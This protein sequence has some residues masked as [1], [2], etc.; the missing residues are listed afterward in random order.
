MSTGDIEKT[1]YATDNKALS[2]QESPHSR[3]GE[4]A[5]GAVADFGE[6]SELK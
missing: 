4:T 1:N 2:D 6:K 5:V 3:D